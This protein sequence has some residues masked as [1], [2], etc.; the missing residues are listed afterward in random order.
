MKTWVIS[1]VDFDLHGAT[2]EVY[3]IEGLFLGKNTYIYVLEPTGKDCKTINSEHIRMKSIPTSCIQCYAEQHKISALGVYKKLYNNG[4]IKL[5]LTND[6]N[7]FVWRNTEDHTISDV[8]DSTRTCKHIR[9][10]SYKFC[11][12]YTGF[13]FYY[14]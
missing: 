14:I 9:D 2:S 4:I 8:S 6:G 5:D 12:N 10:G 13:C 11:I 7:K 3:A 1:H